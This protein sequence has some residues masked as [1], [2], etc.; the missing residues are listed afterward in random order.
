M[1]ALTTRIRNLISLIL[2][3]P[4]LSLVHVDWKG[5]YGAGRV[6]TDHYN[7]TH[8][9]PWITS[10]FKFLEVRHSTSFSVMPGPQD[11]LGGWED[12]QHGFHLL[13]TL[14]S[15]PRYSAPQGLTDFYPLPSLKGSLL[16]PVASTCSFQG[17]W[18]LVPISSHPRGTQVKET[19]KR[20]F[21]STK[22][23]MPLRYDN[24][25][26]LTTY[27]NKWKGK[28]NRNKNYYQPTTGIWLAVGKDFLAKGLNIRING[29]V[30]I[31]PTPGP[32]NPTPSLHW[33]IALL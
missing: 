1:T 8:S 19:G 11:L 21:W 22:Q 18:P 31:F 5:I 29:Q 28:H 32:W 6:K 23:K 3:H 9:L 2:G 30:V 7:S 13:I 20:C 16:Y 10:W 26:G 17:H 12:Y 4:S 14:C 24:T 25:R 33:P 27:W 15:S